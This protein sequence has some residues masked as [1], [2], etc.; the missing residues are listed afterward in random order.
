MGHG[1][2]QMLAGRLGVGFADKNYTFLTEELV[3]I[4]V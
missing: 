2:A 4:V 1:Y 3:E